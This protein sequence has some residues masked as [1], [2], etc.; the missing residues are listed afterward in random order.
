MTKTKSENKNRAFNPY[1]SSFNL[2]QDAITLAVIV[3]VCFIQS[4][5]ISAFYTPNHFLSGG[6]TGLS[7]L[8]DYLFDLPRWVPLVALNIP[9]LII[10]LKPLKV[11]A[12]VFS[13][14]AT[15]SYSILFEIPFIANFRIGLGSDSAL[16]SAI[17]GSAIFG[18]TSAPVVKR[19]ASLGGIDILALIL[20][21]KYSIQMGTICIAFNFVIMTVLGFFYGAQI[22]LTSMLAMFVSNTAFNFA[23]R[24]VNHNMSVFI[25]SEKWEEIAPHVMSDMHRGVTFL[26]GEGAYTGQPRRVVY[27]IVKT[28]ELARLKAIVKMHD[29]KALFSIIETKDVVGR[30]FGALN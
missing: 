15:I 9:V 4:L 19:G 12:V 7:L 11:K 13:A 2:K 5:T 18:V 25:I 14:I 20:S 26:Y 29:N 22:A 23:L 21:R 1:D 16:L 6:I 27:C 24:G 30:G 3:V 17:V 10:G 28:T 8:F